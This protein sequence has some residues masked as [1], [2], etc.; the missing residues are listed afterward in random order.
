MGFVITHPVDWLNNTTN[1]DVFRHVNGCLQPYTH[2]LQAYSLIQQRYSSYQCDLWTRGDNGACRYE[3]HGYFR[4]FLKLSR[5]N[6][7]GYRGSY[8]IPFPLQGD[9]CPLVGA[10]VGQTRDR[11]QAVATHRSIQPPTR[12][13]SNPPSNGA[14]R[15][16]VSR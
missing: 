1:Y 9:G 3:Y 13:Q 11:T 16:V 15:E 5:D 12:R 14:P 8:G 10:G 7:R 4:H 2:E 6:R